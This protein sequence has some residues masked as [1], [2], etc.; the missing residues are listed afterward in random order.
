MQVEISINTRPRDHMKQTHTLEV[1]QSVFLLAVE[2][3]VY[4]SFL[5]S[6]FFRPSL[7]N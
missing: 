5:R 3:T 4:R 2:V 1:L 6:P 7:S